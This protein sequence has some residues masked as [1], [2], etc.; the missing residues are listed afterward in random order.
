MTDCG[1][2]P[3]SEIE[4]LLSLRQVVAVAVVFGVLI[5]ALATTVAY[6][7]GLLRPTSPD[8]GE[9]TA[10]ATATAA[11]A[12]PV[13]TQDAGSEGDRSITDAVS[14]VNADAIARCMERNRAKHLQEIRED[15]ETARRLGI[16]GTPGFA[17]SR[18]GS[19][20]GTTII[21]AQPYSTFERA[22]TTQLNGGDGRSLG[23]VPTA[24]EPVVGS[25]D[26]PVTVV[27]WYDYQCPFCGQ[28]EKRT[29][30]RI[31]REYV[32]NGKVRVVFKD[33]PFIGEGSR[34]AALAAHCVRERSSEQVFLRWHRAVFDSQGKENSGWASKDSLVG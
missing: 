27:Y 29:L 10:A 32:Q 22:I 13:A 7:A 25:D 18:T 5:G 11:A 16:D 19:N 17:V 24:D 30:S 12:R 8:A 21:G 20:T 9:T 2:D 14:G 26:A 28:F 3:G 31:E 1:S 34:T 4:L 23:D 15:M 33:F 6:D